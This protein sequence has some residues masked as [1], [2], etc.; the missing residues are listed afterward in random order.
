MDSERFLKSHR[1]MH[2]RAV[3]MRHTVIVLTWAALFAMFII[4][5]VILWR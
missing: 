2:E 5:A 4:A 1:A 3:R